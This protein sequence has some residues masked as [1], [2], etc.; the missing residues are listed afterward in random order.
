MRLA[1]VIVNR[2]EKRIEGE[3]ELDAGRAPARRVT[4]GWR[5]RPSSQPTRRPAANAAQFIAA[6]S[7]TGISGIRIAGPSLF[8]TA[9]PSA[10]I[11]RAAARRARAAGPT[12]AVSPRRPTP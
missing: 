8:G 12:A 5:K 7:E 4:Q 2:R 9:G 11:A 1:P 10:T 3:D 6:Y